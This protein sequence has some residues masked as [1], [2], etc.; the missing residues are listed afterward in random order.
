MSSGKAKPWGGRFRQGQ[1]SAVES[2]TESVS[3]DR[4][5]YKQDIAGSKAHARML[6]A[7]GVISSQDAQSIVA[8]WIRCSPPSNPGILLG[9]KSWKMCI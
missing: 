1:S 4:L 2:F 9:K 3:Y 8:D 6:A 5:L 7:R